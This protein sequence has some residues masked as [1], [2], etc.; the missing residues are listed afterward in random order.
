M[1]FRI[2]NGQPPADPMA[3][4][5]QM[6]AMAEPEVMADPM[7]EMPIE[8]PMMSEG[9]V[10][11]EAAKYMTSDMRCGSCVHFMDSGGIGS[12]EIVSGP[13]DPQG[14]CL[15]YTADTAPEELAEPALEESPVVAEEAPEEVVTEDTGV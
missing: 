1:A 9:L 10:S 7:M 3:M 12:C 2:S 13:I 11:P 15:L 6:A 5:E 8:E 14:V 4:P